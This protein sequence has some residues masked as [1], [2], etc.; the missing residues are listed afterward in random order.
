[1]P[2]L[3]PKEDSKFHF[4]NYE[5]VSVL[6]IWR[7]ILYLSLYFLNLIFKLIFFP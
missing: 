6:I 1:M 7:I 5:K 3:W 4:M 2:V